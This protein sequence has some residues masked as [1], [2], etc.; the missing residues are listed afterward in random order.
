M[1][2]VE[3]TIRIEPALIDAARPAMESMV[4]QSRAEQGCIDYAYAFDL[5]EPGLIRVIERWQSREALAAHFQTAHLAAWRQSFGKL[6][7]TGRSLRLYD[8]APEDL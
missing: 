3:G 4:R 6:G 2:V 7:I 8:A 5:L 1:I